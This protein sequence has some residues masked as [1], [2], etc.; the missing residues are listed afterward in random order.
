MRH[1]QTEPSPLLVGFIIIGVIVAGTFSAQTCQAQTDE[2]IRYVTDEFRADLRS[3]PSERGK[4]TNYLRAGTQLTLL[5]EN[6]EGWSHVRTGRGTE[7]WLR[8][9]YLVAQQVARVRIGT[10]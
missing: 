5:E 8:S 4:I 10:G 6:Q 7:G 3:I 9:S 2:S 1:T